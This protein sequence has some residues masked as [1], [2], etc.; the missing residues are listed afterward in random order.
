MVGGRERI[1]LSC[2]GCSGKRLQVQ[3]FKV[4]N[5]TYHLKRRVCNMASVAQPVV[6]ICW[7]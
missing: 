3:L 6:D 5:S 2:S 7:A 1:E 4:V